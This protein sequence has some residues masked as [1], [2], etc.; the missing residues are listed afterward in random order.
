ME[1]MKAIILQRP[2][3]KFKA[4]IDW[5]QIAQLTPSA[6]SIDCGRSNSHAWQLLPKIN[7]TKSDLKA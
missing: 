1:R 6:F 2:E 3:P 5:A 7:E 4:S